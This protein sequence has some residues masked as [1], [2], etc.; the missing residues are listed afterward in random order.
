MTKIK[1]DQL[2]WDEF[3][4]KHIK[5]HNVTKEEVQ[6]AIQKVNAHRKGYAERIVIIGRAGKRILAILI[7]PEGDK[8]YYVVTA[9]DADKKERRLLYDN[10]KK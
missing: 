7:S 4:S 9:R 1:I 8:K 5:K 6:E 2:I 3:N 10:E